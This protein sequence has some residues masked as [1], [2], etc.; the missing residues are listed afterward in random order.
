[1]SYEIIK[2]EFDKGQPRFLSALP[3][4]MDIKRLWNGLDMALR[5]NPEIMKC[6]PKSIMYS[7]LRCAELGLSLD[8]RHKQ[9]FIVPF[10][11]NKN[12]N[13]VATSIEGYK[14]LETLA[15]RSGKIKKIWSEVV[16][17]NDEFDIE[18]G[19]NPTL[20]HKPLKEGDRGSMIGV[21][22]VAEFIDGTKQFKYLTRDAVLFYK[23]KSKASK[24]SYSPWSADEESMWRKTSLR[25]LCN[26]LPSSVDDLCLIQA[27]SHDEEDERTDYEPDYDNMIDVTPKEQKSQEEQIADRFESKQSKPVPK[28]PQPEAKREVSTVDQFW[29][30]IKDIADRATGAEGDKFTIDGYI[31]SVVKTVF[32]NQKSIIKDKMSIDDVEILRNYFVTKIEPTIQKQEETEDLTA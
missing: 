6:T 24:T 32:P 1:M 19:D 2:K 14:G 7:V 17:K 10:N 26:E 5:A 18:I 12:G 20:Y 30:E 9:F 25:R 23:A 16:Y 31:N 21:Y 22:S 29:A 3:N 27:I 11:D 13:I 4:N 15:R 28:P 8:P